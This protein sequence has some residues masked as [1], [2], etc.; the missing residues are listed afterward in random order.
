MGEDDALLVYEK[1]DEWLLVK[2]EGQDQL[3]FVPATYVQ[4]EEGSSGQ[5][6]SAADVPVRLLSP[7]L[8][9]APRH[10]THPSGGFSSRSSG[11]QSTPLSPQG[12]VDPS[13]RAASS[14]DKGKADSIQTWVVSVSR[15][16]S[17]YA[18]ELLLTR[19]CRCHATPGGRPEK[20]EEEGHTGDRERSRLLR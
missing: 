7:P 11:S 12:Y 5:G 3:G 18:Y 10:Q 8:S 9:C 2:R 16:I 20:E 15:R 4:E 1:D 13:E 6:F 19:I 14:R 17:L